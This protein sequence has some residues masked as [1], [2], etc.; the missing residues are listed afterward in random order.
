[1]KN[2][3]VFDRL[4][5][6]QKAFLIIIFLIPLFLLEILTFFSSPED[7]VTGKVTN[8]EIPRG[9]ALTQIAD[10]LLAKKL[11]KDKDVFVLLAK[12]LGYEKKMRAGSF[13]IQNGL[14][15]YQVVNYLISARENTTAITLLEGWELEQIASEVEKKL[16]IPS[17]QFMELCFDS[18]FI[19]EFGLNVK[20]LEGYLLPET[21]HFAKGE[22]VYEVIKHL[23]NQTLTIFKADSVQTRL[24][25]LRLS[26]HEILTLASIVEGEA[27]KDDERPIIASLYY[28]RLKK[29]MRLQA[30]PTIQYIV[31]GPPKRLLNK[32]LEIESPYNTYL[33]YGLPPGPINNPGRLSIL[34]TIFPTETNYLYMVAIGNGRH[35]FTT[36]LKDHIK[37]KTEFDKVR[38]QVARER[39]KKGSN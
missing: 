11:I 28:N 12:S 22:N 30:D 26:Q 38:R 4:S 37:A 33:Y 36:N 6:K 10:T 27:L 13:S 32:D 1:M 19:S 39:R 9:A 20:N 34:G 25:E 5:G 29:R 15:D 21:Y 3:P 17:E 16:N 14:N 8:I 35:T 7:V 31:D 18:L 2:L 24:Q 23:V